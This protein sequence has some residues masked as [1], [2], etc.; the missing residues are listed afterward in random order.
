MTIHHE[1]LNNVITAPTYTFEDK[2]APAYTIPLLANIAVTTNSPHPIKIPKDDRRWVA[3]RCFNTHMKDT[4]YHGRVR[5][6]FGEI[7]T[8]RTP[9]QLG[10]LRGLYQAFK[11]RDVEGI[12]T[13]LTS[14]RPMTDF[15]KECTLVH[16]PLITKFLSYLTCDEC[17]AGVPNVY[18]SSN[19]FRRCKEWAERSGF[20]FDF[21]TTTFGTEMTSFTK[22]SST[23]IEKKRE[24][25]G[26]EYHV[27]VRKLEAFLKD[28]GIF[29][30][31]S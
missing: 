6:Y 23:G 24:A 19:L 15:Y 8:P 26:K 16:A 29:D 20:K 9:S 17:G 2:H 27:D 12:K 4:K 31:N 25:S 5:A 1:K 21:N 10:V 7:E 18:S 13:A 14:N 3:A 30:D 28:E 22:Y 11:S